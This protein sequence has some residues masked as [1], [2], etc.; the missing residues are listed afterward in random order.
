MAVPPYVTAGTA[1]EESW[2][3]QIADSVVNPF[4]TAAARS[5]AITSPTAGMTTA[6]TAANATNGL[7]VWN[8][9]SWRMPW[10]MPWGFVSYLQNTTTGTQTMVT[11]TVVTGL[12]GTM[13][14]VA[15]RRYRATFQL[16]QAGANAVGSYEVQD[17]GVDVGGTA[18]QA[19]TAGLT[20]NTV[21]GV[22]YF[23]SSASSARTIRVVGTSA[24]NT[25][26]LEVSST[27]RQ[28]L[29]VEDIGPAGAPS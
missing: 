16:N 7:E 25:A 10:N 23:V 9:T 22:I 26:V 29:L 11:N 17:N 6:L 4:T 15:N 21:M 13:T 18:I 24:A 27:I 5:A 28:S 12:T 20:S 2:G 8:G 3:D 1:I 14:L 19:I